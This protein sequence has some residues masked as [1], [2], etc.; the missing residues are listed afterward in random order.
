VNFLHILSFQTQRNH[1]LANDSKV[2][3]PAFHRIYKALVEMADDIY[4]VELK[5]KV[6]APGGCRHGLMI[7][8]PVP[9]VP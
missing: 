3:E 5:K 2:E 4:P 1:S 9:P 7:T 8:S 6:R